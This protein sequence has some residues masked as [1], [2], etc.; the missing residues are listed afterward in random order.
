MA[1]Y[2]QPRDNGE[3]LDDSPVRSRSRARPECENAPMVAN[4]PHVPMDTVLTWMQAAEGFD[5]RMLNEIET[6]HDA[7]KEVIQFC[8]HRTATLPFAMGLRLC[9][10]LRQAMSNS[11]ATAQPK[12]V[13]L[14]DDA[15]DL[16]PPQRPLH[17]LRL[18]SEEK[19]HS[20]RSGMVSARR[21]FTKILSLEP[22]IQRHLV[23]A[24][25][26]CGI[27][28]VIYALAPSSSDSIHP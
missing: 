2:C 27:D 13:P 24:D 3:R 12:T 11:K 19:K 25:L 22:H 15:V 26:Q 21:F 1:S 5:R 4:W 18:L 7:C 10:Q 16:L 28:D 14:F 20:L 8:G 9:V 23:L 17:H 6:V